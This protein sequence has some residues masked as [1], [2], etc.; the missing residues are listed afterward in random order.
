MVM[1]ARVFCLRDWIS[2]RQH[3]FLV[4]RENMRMTREKGKVS[5]NTV[6]N[7][8]LCKLHK[9]RRDGGLGCLFTGTCGC[10]G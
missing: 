1:V 10:A 4:K 2:S 5:L 7:A 9:E 8:S 3:F 6:C